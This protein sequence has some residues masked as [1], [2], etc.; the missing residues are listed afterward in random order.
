MCDAKLLTHPHPHRAT[1][2][3]PG[4]DYDPRVQFS[5]LPKKETSGTRAA[6]VD[7]AGST[8]RV[9]IPL[10]RDGGGDDLRG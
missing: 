7:A 1:L 4:F 6:S 2:E 8:L 9:W 5:S 10:P 3:R